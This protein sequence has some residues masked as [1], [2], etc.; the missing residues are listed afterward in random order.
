MAK[1]PETICNNAL[2]R[3]GITTYVDDLET[4]QTNEAE[5]LNVFYEDAL[6]T[7]LAAFPWPFATLRKILAPL[8][9]DGE[10]PRGAWKY[11]FKLPDDCVSARQIWP[12]G[13]A[14]GLTGYWLGDPRRTLRADDRIP[15]AI[16]KA[17]SDDS[18]VLLCDLSDPILFY[19]AK[20]ADPTKFPALFVDAFAACL[21]MH[22]AIPLTGK[23]EFKKAM[24]EEFN[25]A[26]HEAEAAALN[27]QRED[28]PPETES[29][30]VRR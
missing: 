5:T 26:I 10:P 1:G 23:A 21:A 30:A 2:S 4:D 29:I 22:V 14:L 3:L 17:V 12:S 15:F 25:E 27:E 9:S 19:T 11:I 8:V 24:K 13:T 28:P 7:V 16:E 18:R 20:V 6:E